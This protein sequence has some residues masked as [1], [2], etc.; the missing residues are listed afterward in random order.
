MSALALI[1]GKL[2]P[3]SIYT[4]SARALRHGEVNY[5]I[6]AWEGYAHLPLSDSAIHVLAGRAVFV[7]E[8]VADRPTACAA[9]IDIGKRHNWQTSFVIDRTGGVR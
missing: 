2:Q 7:R 1:S 3:L 6:A 5:R 8:I 4:L 9:L